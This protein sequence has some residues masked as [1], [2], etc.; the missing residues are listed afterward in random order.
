MKRSE[1]GEPKGGLRNG[2]KG[3][4]NPGSLDCESGI[5]PLSYRAPQERWRDREEGWERDGE[6]ERKD[7]RD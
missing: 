7:G 5:L 2:S 4:S 1:N 3:D 6:T